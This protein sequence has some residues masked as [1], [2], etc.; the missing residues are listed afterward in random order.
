MFKVTNGLN[1]LGQ[2]KVES[3]TKLY[4]YVKFSSDPR[5]LLKAFLKHPF[6]I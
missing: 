4:L 1:L 6:L 5:T 2:I 3:E